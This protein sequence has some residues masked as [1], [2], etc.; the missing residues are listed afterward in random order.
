MGNAE[1]VKGLYFRQIL[2]WL[3]E[4]QIGVR[5]VWKQGDLLE[6]CGGHL[7]ETVGF[8]TWAVV[9]WMGGD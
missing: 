2:W 3:C 1:P 4:E 9:S 5:P 8:P 6:G 7:A